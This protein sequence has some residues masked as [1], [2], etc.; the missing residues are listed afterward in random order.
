MLTVI[1]KEMQK[2]FFT[3][4]SYRISTGNGKAMAW[5]HAHGKI[6]AQKLEDDYIH[7]TVQLSEENIRRFEQI[8]ANA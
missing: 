6:L 2:R 3:E 7:V 8:H 4:A 5:L 1:E